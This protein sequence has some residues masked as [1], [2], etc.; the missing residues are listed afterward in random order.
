MFRMVITK[1]EDAVIHFTFCVTHLFHSKTNLTKIEDIYDSLMGIIL[2]QSCKTGCTKPLT[3]K[4]VNVVKPFWFVAFF[5]G[6]IVIRIFI[7]L[8]ISIDKLYLNFHHTDNLEF[9]LYKMLYM[10]MN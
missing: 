5:Q 3:P 7:L 9:N 8:G 4:D 6:N 2:T 10:T 1:R